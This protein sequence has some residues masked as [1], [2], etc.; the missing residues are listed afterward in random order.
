MSTEYSTSNKRYE[1]ILLAE[2]KS[3]L[4]KYVRVI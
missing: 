3:Y 4:D 2:A 1:N